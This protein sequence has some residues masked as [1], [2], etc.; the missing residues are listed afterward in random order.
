MTLPTEYNITNLIV[1]N[2]GRHLLAFCA[3]TAN[4]SH[5]KRARAKLFMI[6]TLTLEFVRELDI[7]AQIEGSINVG[8]VIYVTYENNLGYF[9][10]DGIT[11]LRK[12]KNT[13]TTTT[14]SHNLA[15][16]EGIL[17]VR[18]EGSLLFYGN[19]GLGNVFWYPWTN[20]PLIKGIFYYGDNKMLTS[21]SDQR[22]SLLDFDTFAGSG[23]LES[24][25]YTFPSK[26]W[27]RKIVVQ[28]EALASGS[29]ISFV[30]V[31]KNGTTST[32][33]TMNHTTDGAISEKTQFCNIFTDVFRLR[34][35]FDFLQTK[36]VRKIIIYYED[37]E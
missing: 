10:G 31:D 28:T 12:L 3:E 7:D 13:S 37:G 6:D 1:H 15:N 11:F 14:Y 2:D 22:M 8:G 21:S 24:N 16:V 25:P 29:N 27:I 20:T 30:S 23:S 5:T 18:E 9:N 34:I 26:V 32:I 19:L 4:F 17:A 36:G 35:N 33:M